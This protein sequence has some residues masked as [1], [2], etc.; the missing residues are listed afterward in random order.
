[1]YKFMQAHFLKQSFLKTKF[2]IHKTDE[3]AFREN[4]PLNVT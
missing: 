4:L 2:I 1:M 3:N